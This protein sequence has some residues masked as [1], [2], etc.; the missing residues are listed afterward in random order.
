MQSSRARR[1]ETIVFSIKRQA[2]SSWHPPQLIRHS[3]C[4]GSHQASLDPNRMPSLCNTHLLV[5]PIQFIIFL[6]GVRL[7]SSAELVAHAEISTV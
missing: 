7:A 4:T 5:I 6:L 1:L 2:P 3:R